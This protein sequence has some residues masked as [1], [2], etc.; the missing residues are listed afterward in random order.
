MMLK[1]QK[2]RFLRY[3]SVKSRDSY[4]TEISK[5]SFPMIL[6]YKSLACSLLKHQKRISYDTEVSKN[7]IRLILNIKRC[8]RYGIE[9]S[10]TGLI[11]YWG[12]KRR[13]FYDNWLVV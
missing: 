3:W 2:A 8:V 7:A 4:D 11:W 10:K 6:K 5:G 13:F 1:Y 12:I 9:V